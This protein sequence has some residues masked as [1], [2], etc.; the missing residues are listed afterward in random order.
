MAD[1]V[2]FGDRE[3]SPEEKTRR[4]GEVFS[5]VARRYDLTNAVLSAGLDRFQDEVVAA[6]LAQLDN[7]GLNSMPSAVA[8]RASLHL[9][10]V[11][12]FS[13]GLEG[14]VAAETEVR[15]VPAVPVASGPQEAATRARRETAASSGRIKS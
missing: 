12:D 7:H 6:L 4:V 10:L 9:G 3:V 13:P 15:G 8:D 5:S 1:K 11:P 14:V 2:S